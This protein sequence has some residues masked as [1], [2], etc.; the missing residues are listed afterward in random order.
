[1]TLHP[2]PSDPC[3]DCGSIVHRVPWYRHG[4]HIE[5]RLRCLRTGTCGWYSDDPLPPEASP[6]PSDVDPDPMRFPA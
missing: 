6:D 3:P 1:M 5:D 2:D 4:E